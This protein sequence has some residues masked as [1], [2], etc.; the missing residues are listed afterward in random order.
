M[1]MKLRNA[2][3]ATI[4]KACSKVA[5]TSLGFFVAVTYHNLRVQ[6][7][8]NFQADVIPL[9]LSDNLVLHVAESRRPFSIAYTLD[10]ARG[11]PEYPTRMLQKRET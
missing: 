7:L 11:D 2:I 1:A 4:F 10:S 3:Y 8:A 9:L 6:R 5:S